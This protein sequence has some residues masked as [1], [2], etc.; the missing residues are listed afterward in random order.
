MTKD[1]NQS[2]IIL[3]QTD[4]GLTKLQVTMEDET[5]WFMKEKSL[6]KQVP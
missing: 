3:Y 4:D 1:K 5:V 6:R 2:Q